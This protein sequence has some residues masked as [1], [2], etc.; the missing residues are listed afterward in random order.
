MKLSPWRCQPEMCAKLRLNTRSRRPLGLFHVSST[1]PSELT[2]IFAID[3]QP[4]NWYIKYHITFR[5]KKGATRRERRQGK[6]GT[7]RQRSES[8]QTRAIKPNK[9]TQTEEKQLPTI[10]I[11]CFL[12]VQHERKNFWGLESL[13]PSCSQ[14]AAK[15]HGMTLARVYRNVAKTM[16]KYKA[17]TPQKLSR[18]QK[19]ALNSPYT[20]CGTREVYKCAQMWV[21]TLFSAFLRGFEPRELAKL[22]GQQNLFRDLAFFFLSLKLFPLTSQ[23]ACTWK[24]ERENREY[25][26]ARL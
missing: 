19:D 2:S 3:E 26:R 22:V 16:N 18:I 7:D 5:Q 8:K 11:C 1:L 14:T 24:S 15:F 20:V 10:I 6:R 23:R 13:K 9:Q 21:S 17:Y 25:G 12:K 4:D